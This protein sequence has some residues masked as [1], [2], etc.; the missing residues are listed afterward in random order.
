MRIQKKH[1]D[2]PF[3]LIRMFYMEILQRAFDLVATQ[4]T[5]ANRHAL[6]DTINENFYLLRVGSPGTAGLTVGVADI[7][8]INYALTANFTKLS[9]TLSHLLQ[10]YVTS[11]R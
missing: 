8:A 1:A 10:G 4:A 5:S 2:L 3:R 9:H 11:N 7:V 6:R